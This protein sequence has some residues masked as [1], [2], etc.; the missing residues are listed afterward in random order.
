MEISSFFK[1][2]EYKRDELLV[3]L[4]DLMFVSSSLT[5]FENGVEMTSVDGCWKGIQINKNSNIDNSYSITIKSLDKQIPNGELI[6]RC[7]LNR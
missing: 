6:F 4:S 2:K 3:D 5:K 7:I 1:S